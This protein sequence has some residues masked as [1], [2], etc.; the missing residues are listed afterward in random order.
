MM[1]DKTFEALLADYQKRGKRMVE[2][3]EL[4]RDMAVAASMLLEEHGCDFFRMQSSMSGDRRT[5]ADRLMELGFF[6]GM[7]GERMSER[8]GGCTSA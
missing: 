7:E 8:S 2:L 6:D 5:F 1:S 3:E 4:C